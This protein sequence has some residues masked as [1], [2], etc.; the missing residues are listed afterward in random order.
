MV[1]LA[2]PPKSFGAPPARVA[3]APKAVDPFYLSPEWRRLSGRIKRERG[4]R[5]EQC[6]RDAS[7]T[8]MGLMVDH[9]HEIRDGGARLDHANLRV[10]CA[11]C[12]AHKTAA[13]ARLRAASVV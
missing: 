7:P 2:R 9:V 13:A 8:G 11:A 3:A 1:K 6:G 10:L 12:H 5:C 4:F